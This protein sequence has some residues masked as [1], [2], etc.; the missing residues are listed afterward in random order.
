MTDKQQRVFYV[1]GTNNRDEVSDDEVC[2]NGLGFTG[3]PLG[4]ENLE[5]LE[6]WEGIFQSGKSQGILMRLEKSG[7][8]QGKSHKNNRDGVSDDE[9]CENGLGFTLR[10]VNSEDREF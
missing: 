6:K 4:L 10:P 1:R 2:E 7:K 5:N 3:F 9:V 8:S